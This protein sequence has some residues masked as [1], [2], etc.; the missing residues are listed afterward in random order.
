MGSRPAD[1]PELELV[2]E[3]KLDRV[4]PGGGSPR[5]EASGVLARD[6]ELLVIFDDST[7]I[8]VVADIRDPLRN[9][10]V[11]PN[12]LIAQ[13]G[14][15]GVGYEDLARDP[16]ERRIY[17][18]VEAALELGRLLPRIEVVDDQFVRMSEAF[19]DFPLEA[20]NKGM[21]GLT[22]ARRLGQ[23]FL[24]CMCEGNLCR[25]GVEG[26]RPG[27]GR[28][29]VFRE[30]GGAWLHDGTI[31]LPSD[32]WF[33]DYS[34]LALRGDRLV[35]VSQQSSAIW[36]GTF[37]SSEWTFIDGGQAFE[38][39]RAPDG[40]MAYGTAEGVTWINDDQ[41]AVVSDRAP[42]TIPEWRAKDRSLHIFTFG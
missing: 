2:F 35:V 3:A 18:L 4:L 1:V 37:N 12:P 20:E 19:L 38:F 8:G 30:E 6:Q 22:F 42:V 40:T 5:G 15:L 9:S 33:I 27:G 36:V 16:V 25:G 24:L 14:S 32:L 23:V 31:R 21:E 11:E 10:V 13:G 29:Q 39:P 17:L 7:Q 28:I 41:L 26:R 34:S